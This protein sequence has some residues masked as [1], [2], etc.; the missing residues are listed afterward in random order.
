M[1][2]D[3]YLEDD[4][5]NMV[6]GACH[7]CGCM[8]LQE[9]RTEYFHEKITHNLVNMANSCGLYDVMWRPEENGIQTASQMIPFLREGVRSLQE[10][11]TVHMNYEPTNGFGTYDYLLKF[12][13]LYLEACEKFPTSKV[14][15]E[16]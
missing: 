9:M 10:D 7:A 15:V 5:V 13:R 6:E 11:A 8:Q 1:G 12:V 16:R 3:V 4:T 2:L 14:R